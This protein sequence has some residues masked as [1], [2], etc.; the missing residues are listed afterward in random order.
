MER[1]FIKDLKTK[2]GQQVTL[3]GWL[4]TLRDQKSMHFLTPRY[5]QADLDQVPE[6]EILIHP[7]GEIRFSGIEPLQW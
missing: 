3:K 7:D 1:T 4:Q 2:I 6:A 5:T